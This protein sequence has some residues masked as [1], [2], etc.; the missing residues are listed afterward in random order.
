MSPVDLLIKYHYFDFRTATLAK[1]IELHIAN[2]QQHTK[3][4]IQINRLSFW[5]L[6]P[7]RFNRIDPLLP[8]NDFPMLVINNIHDPKITPIADIV[9]RIV[10]FL[11]NIFQ[12]QTI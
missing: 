10:L 6:I 4:T 9:S 8:V 12:L 3:R 2:I 7:K 5:S 1:L 11:T